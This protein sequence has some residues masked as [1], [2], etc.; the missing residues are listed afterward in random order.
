LAYNTVIYKK[1]NEKSIRQTKHDVGS[2]R[3]K[4]TIVCSEL[5]FEV[6]NSPQTRQRHCLIVVELESG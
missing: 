3:K 4:S 6:L 1:K 5:D 2:H